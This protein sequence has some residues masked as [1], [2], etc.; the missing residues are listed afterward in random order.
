MF[1]LMF[2]VT[3]FSYQRLT[4]LLQFKRNNLILIAEALV[5]VNS[6]GF[7]RFCN[8]KEG[9]AGGDS[10]P[11]AIPTASHI[12]IQPQSAETSSAESLF[13]IFIVSALNEYSHYTVPFPSAFYLVLR[14]TYYYLHLRDEK[15]SGSPG[16][17]SR[18]LDIRAQ[19][20]SI[21]LFCLVETYA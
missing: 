16:F 18:L 8:V 6:T 20:G 3:F 7:H 10:S 19:A 15:L 13:N 9:K 21:K 12:W 11:P 1:S 14:A 5:T 2:S 17:Q 4:S